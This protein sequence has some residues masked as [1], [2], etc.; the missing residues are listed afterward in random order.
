V[1]GRIAER[2]EHHYAIGDGGVDAAQS[3]VAVQ[4]LGGEVYGLGD[5]TLAAALWEPRLCDAQYRVD[6]FEEPPPQCGSIGPAD[7][8][9]YLFGRCAEQL[10][11]CDTARVAGTRTQCHQ[12]Q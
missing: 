3:I 12:D 1:I 10:L 5:R 6:A 2:V 7:P 4:T 11:Y 8:I 9:A